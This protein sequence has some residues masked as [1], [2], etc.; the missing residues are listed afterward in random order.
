MSMDDNKRE[1]RSFFELSARGDVAGALDLLADDVSWTVTGT[2]PFSGTYAGKQNLVTKLVEPLFSRLKA[3]I[4]LAIS[5][6][7]AE[8]DFVV[9]E[10]KGTAETTDGRAYNN[11]YCFVIRVSG[12][13]IRTLAEY[14]D[15]ALVNSVFGAGSRA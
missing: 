14:M 7:V 8:G 1:A 5:N 12:G 4:T 2:T 11:T 6:M 3:G 10:G 9:V 13:K 15:T